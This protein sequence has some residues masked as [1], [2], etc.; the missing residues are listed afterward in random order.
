MNAKLQTEI[1]LA[2]VEDVRR[3]MVE[4]T[5]EHFPV[6]VIHLCSE[7]QEFIWSVAGTEY[8]AHITRRTSAALT[9][10]VAGPWNRLDFESLN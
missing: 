10:R 4:R 5:L 9:G 6:P 3:W 2:L 7:D 1:A 8:L